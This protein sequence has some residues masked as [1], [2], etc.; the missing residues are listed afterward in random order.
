MIDR[1]VVRLPVVAPEDITSPND[2]FVCLPYSTPTTTMS[3]VV[4][5]CLLRQAT[6]RA[7]RRSLDW[8]KCGRYETVKGK[9]V[10]RPCELGAL[11]EKNA[12]GPMTIDELGQDSIGRQKGG[13][14][15]NFKPPAASRKNNARVAGAFV[16]EE[17]P[18]CEHP[19]CS[20]TRM[21][22]GSTVPGGDGLCK[23]HRLALAFK[24]KQEKKVAAK[25][26]EEPESEPKP[27]ATPS[28]APTPDRALPLRP[29]HR[30]HELEMGSLLLGKGDDP[31]AVTSAEQA[32]ELGVPWI[33]PGPAPVYRIEPHVDAMPAVVG[34]VKTL[35]EV[36]EETAEVKSPG[37]HAEV[38]FEPHDTER[39]APA[40]KT[41]PAPPPEHQEEKPM[42]TCTWAGCKR[43]VYAPREGKKVPEGTETLC[44]PHRK[45]YLRKH[46]PEHRKKFLRVQRKHNAETK[47]LVTVAKRAESGQGG[48]L[49]D[50]LERA[51]RAR[52]LRAAV[53]AL[54]SPIRSVED[55]V[56]VLV[57]AIVELQGGAS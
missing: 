6:V 56:A 31:I 10:F 1:A 27:I 5:G 2:R 34:R 37:V 35:Q 45:D 41:D 23:G 48:D 33:E 25:P 42:T 40:A 11:V 44:G 18:K 30:M 19:G 29:P 3:L 43:S 36:M 24:L 20:K 55:R 47:R 51:I 50:M 9:E 46:D 13:W 21:R 14:H 38:V 4:R 54:L 16:G 53:L 22:V 8:S 52:G 39:P 28:S 12:G 57:D 15:G 32:K 26:V 49:D 17:L 7:R